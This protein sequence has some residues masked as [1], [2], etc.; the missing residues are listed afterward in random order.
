MTRYPRY[1]LANLEIAP[2]GE[3]PALWTFTRAP[4]KG[5]ELTY[6]VTDTNFPSRN[7]WEFLV[8]V[9]K[10]RDDR[11]EVRPRATPNLKVWAG[12]ERRSVTFTRARRSNYRG[13]HYAQISLADPTGE[14]TRDILRQADRDRLPPW[15]DELKSRI[16]L[17]DTVRATKGHDEDE[18]IVLVRPNEHE[19]MI[20]LFFASK[21]WV[22]KERFKLD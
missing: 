9:P 22:L 8:R 3:R 12:L 6:T 11:I 15:F 5:T 10:D 19:L 13:W 7:A 18:L 21:I 1:R 2:A 17:K 4:V 16:R 20:G 14:R